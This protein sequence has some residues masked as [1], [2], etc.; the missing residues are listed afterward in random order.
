MI[1]AFGAVLGG[2]APILILKKMNFLRAIKMTNVMFLISFLLIAFFPITAVFLESR[3]LAG[4]SNSSLRVLRK[5]V[6]FDTLERALH[7]SPRSK[8]LLHR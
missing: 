6:M 7:D 4:M 2:L 8:S 5:D 3:V 1:F